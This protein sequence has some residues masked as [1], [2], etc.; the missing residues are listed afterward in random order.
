MMS[1][2]VFRNVASSDSGGIGKYETARCVSVVPNMLMI[3][4]FCASCCKRVQSRF[5]RMSPTKNA[6]RSEGIR[7][8]ACAER[9]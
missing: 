6:L 4:Q 5:V 3:R 2:R 9:S 7:L 8:V 1:L